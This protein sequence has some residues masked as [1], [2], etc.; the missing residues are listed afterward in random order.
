MNCWRNTVK[1]FKMLL[2]Y[3]GSRYKGWQRLGNGENTIQAKLEAVLS[4]MVEQPVEVTG[5]GR[6]DAGVHA[7]GQVA[8]FHADTEMTCEDILQYLRRYLPEDI[9]VVSV[10]EAD[11]RFH[12]R[13]NAVTKVYR[14]RVWRSEEPCVFQRKY[15]WTMTEPL[16]LAA[17]N[18]AARLLE[19]TH[20]FRSFCSNKHMKK[21]SVRRLDSIEIREQGKELW[22]TFCGNGF[23]YHMV[24]ILVG[25]LLAVGQGEL[26]PRQMSEILEQK[27]RE[28]AGVTVPAKGLCL[29]EVSYG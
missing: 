26:Q 10:E 17:M 27:N 22:L 1:N 11:P 29:M 16:D 28:A 24:R 5:S 3:D 21:S 4:K 18:E 7:Q 13:L 6:T 12:S 19:G 14:Y 2:S 9:G 8:N 23:L 15:V 25:T 20:D